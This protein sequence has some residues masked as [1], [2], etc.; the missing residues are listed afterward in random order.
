MIANIKKV[1]QWHLR[2]IALCLLVSWLYDFI[3]L[4]LNTNNYWSSQIYDGDVERTLR[5]FVILI[6]FLAFFFKVLHFLV[7]WKVSVEFNRFFN[8]DMISDGYGM[9]ASTKSAFV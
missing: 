1:R 5:R 8:E 2:F 9:N 6:S 4:I 7:F 3:W